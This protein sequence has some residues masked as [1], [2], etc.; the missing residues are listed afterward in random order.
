MPSNVLELE[1]TWMVQTL[2]SQ[3]GSVFDIASQQVKSN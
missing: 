2:L 1:P 3:E